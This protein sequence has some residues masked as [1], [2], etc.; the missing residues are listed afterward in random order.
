MIF[1]LLYGLTPTGCSR[2]LIDVLLWFL[3]SE[4]KL[5]MELRVG[6]VIGKYQIRM[7]PFLCDSLN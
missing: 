7:K 5:C 6:D 3:M 1:L 2:H 4:L